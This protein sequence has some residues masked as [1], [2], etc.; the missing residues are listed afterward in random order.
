MT[1]NMWQQFST[2]PKVEK[3]GVWLDYDTFRV[4]VTHAGQTNK[5]Y[6]KLLET[7]TR[8]HRRQIANGTFS[9]ERSLAIM[10]QVYAETVVMDWETVVGEDNAIHER[11]FERGIQAKDGTILPFT[12]DNVV[13]VFKA[14]PRLFLDIRDQSESIVNFRSEEIEEEAKNS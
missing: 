3:E 4:K 10:H 11:I 9:N 6:T 8:S 13:A 2:D 5:K 1:T 12:K 14:L 7:L